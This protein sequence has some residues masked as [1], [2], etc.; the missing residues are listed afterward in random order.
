MS[1]PIIAVVC[2]RGHQYQFER[3]ST[4]FTIHII[5]LLFYA[6]VCDLSFVS[7][8]YTVR[9]DEG[10]VSVCVSISGVPSGGLAVDLVVE[11]SYL[12]SDKTS[13]IYS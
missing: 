1:L 7:T 12:A 6:V 4:C 3:T 13:E 8:S 9:E 5:F 2:D 10:S 11:F